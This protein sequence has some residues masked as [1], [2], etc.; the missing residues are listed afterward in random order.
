MEFQFLDKVM[1]KSKLRRACT[2]LPG[3]YNRK[4]WVIQRYKHPRGGVVIGWRTLSNGEAEYWSDEP[5]TYRPKEHFKVL[6]VVMN[7][8]QNPVYVLPEE[9]YER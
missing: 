9:V 1:V 2:V 3:C 7:E 4:E 6:L 5:V 8:K